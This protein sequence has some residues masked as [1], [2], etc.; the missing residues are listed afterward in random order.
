MIETFDR[1]P[2]HNLEAE[3]SILGCCLLD[4]RALLTVLNA[5]KP[6]DFY[7]PPHRIIFEAIS[8]LFTSNTSPDYVTLTNQLI[9]T[10]NLEAAGSGEYIAGL[11]N[12]VPSV[13]SAEHY[14]KIVTD[15]ARLRN[16]IRLGHEIAA[17]AYEQDGKGPDT[18]LNQ[19]MSG[20]LDISRKSGSDRAKNILQTSKES[21]QYAEDVFHGRRPPPITLGFQQL[22]KQLGLLPGEVFVIGGVTSTGKTSL[23]MN[24]MLN[25]ARNGFAS[26]MI[27]AEMT[28]R[29]M[30][31]R[32]A[33]MI[34]GLPGNNFR[35]GKFYLND[36]PEKKF[37]YDQLVHLSDKLYMTCMSGASEVDII[38]FATQEKLEHP[39]INLIVIDYLQNFTAEIQKRQY[40]PQARVISTVSK[41]ISVLSKKLDVAIILLSQLK[42]RETGNLN[43]KPV[44]SDLKESGDI[45]GDADIVLLMHL[46]E[47]TTDGRHLFLKD[48]DMEWIIAKAR[49][50]TTG[51]CYAKLHRPT[52][53]FTEIVMPPVGGTP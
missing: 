34:T 4:R 35:Y 52:T 43:R 36:M 11:T 33:S 26:L 8:I 49:D 18:I 27:S 40:I 50:S 24:F 20:V 51:I 53:T 47:D 39:E 38:R 15:T 10:S 45:E 23:A 46:Q 7:H 2:P 1:A 12:V 42:R 30:D 17:S 41:A 28:E 5:V 19:A 25:N 22:D 44:L 3:R 16:L 48:W 13:R 6:D 21:H 32:F 29:K 31:H 14:A 37:Y 9:A